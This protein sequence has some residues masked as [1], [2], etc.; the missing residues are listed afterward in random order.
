MTTPQSTRSGRTA[1]LYY[2][3]TRVAEVSLF[4]LRGPRRVASLLLI[5]IL[6]ASLSGCSSKGPRFVDEGSSYSESSVMVI[7]DEVD[8]SQ[9]A[10]TPST[11]GPALRHEAL[12]ALRALGGRAVPVA[13]LITKTFSAETRAVPVYFERTTF[14][15]KPAIVMIEAAGPAKGKLT[16]KRVWV[17]DEQGDVLYVGGR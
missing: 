17:L 11:E 1:V 12:T 10:N 16:A 4:G 5:L 13:D 3:S 9:L 2:G 8:T 6:S 14:D 15:G 7:A